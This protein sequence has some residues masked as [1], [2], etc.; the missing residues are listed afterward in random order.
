M[1]LEL[2]CSLADR[3]PRLVPRPGEVVLWPGS[4]LMASDAV[5]RAVAFLKQVPLPRLGDHFDP[6]SRQHAKLVD[7]LLDARRGPQLT[8]EDLPIPQQLQTLQVLHFVEAQQVLVRFPINKP[9]RK[10]QDGQTFRNGTETRPGVQLVV[11]S[12]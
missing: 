4:P 3:H 2:L 7:Q 10:T 8:V 5:V 9:G 12:R 1:K 11:V 6:V